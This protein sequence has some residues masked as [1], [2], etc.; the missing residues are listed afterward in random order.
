LKIIAKK[1]G[2]YFKLAVSLQ[3]EITIIK[4]SIMNYYHRLRD[5]NGDTKE[6]YVK[7]SS[8]KDFELLDKCEQ[9]GWTYEIEYYFN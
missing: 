6:V 9:F 5:A 3:K 7:F 4:I 8:E 2:L 1:F